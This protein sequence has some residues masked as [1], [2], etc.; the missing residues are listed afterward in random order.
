MTEQSCQAESEIATLQMIKSLY[1]QQ[2][3]LSS[4]AK[5]Y[6]VQSSLC[7]N[8]RAKQFLNFST[9]T[10]YYSPM[11]N[12]HHG[13]HEAAS[14]ATKLQSSFYVTD[15]HNGQFRCTHFQFRISGLAKQKQTVHLLTIYVISDCFVLLLCLNLLLQF[16][17]EKMVV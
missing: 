1:L 5:L 4:G 14:V 15:N 2:H 12:E 7:N 13:S 6:I 17:V 16:S 9:I 11:C 3:G 8:S 10:A